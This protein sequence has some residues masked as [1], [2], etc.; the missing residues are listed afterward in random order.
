MRQ[1]RGARNGC[2]DRLLIKAKKGP[3]IYMC[4]SSGFLKMIRL[5]ERESRRLV[6]KDKFNMKR[7][8]KKGEREFFSLVSPFSIRNSHYMGS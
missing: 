8:K 1:G 4:L 6:V 7:L 3:N 2:P 5:G